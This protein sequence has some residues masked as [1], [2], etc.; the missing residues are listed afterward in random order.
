M[1]GSSIPGPTCQIHKP[2]QIKDGTL[3]LISTPAPTVCGANNASIAGWSLTAKLVEA[4]R[5][6]IPKVPAEMRNQFAAMIS[7]ANIAITGGVLAAWA[8]SH[9]F[10]VGEVADAVV[11]VIGA[12]ML[13]W[14]AGQAAVEMGRYVVIASTAKTHSDLESAATHLANAVAIVGVT[15][16]AMCIAK[17][18]GKPLGRALG[19]AGVRLSSQPGEIGP[20]WE[21]PEDGVGASFPGTSIPRG[22]LMRVG[23]RVFRVTANASKHMA[24]YATKAPT[25]G[26]L[27]E[28]GA[29]SPNPWNKGASVQ[30]PF[31]SLAGTLEQAAKRLNGLPGQRHM[32]DV[33]NWELG[34]DTADKPWAVFHAVPK[35]K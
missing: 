29:W 7:P 10:G 2:V 17:A 14:Q 4:W 13:G 31:S 25:A 3:I 8:G 11:G 1:P 33:G 22:F 32:I 26:Q 9:F 24:E 34:I 5:L 20:W 27:R 18:A 30:Y 12:A 6:A 35:G 23:G 16:I 15:A 21:I 28:P 19:R